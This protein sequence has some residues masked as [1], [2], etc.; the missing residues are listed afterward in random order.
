MHGP[1]LVHSL[2]REHPAHWPLLHDLPKGQSPQ[3]SVPPQPSGAV[4][5]VRPRAAQVVG[6]QGATQPPFWQTCPLPQQVVPQQIRSVP[7]VAPATAGAC[8]QA[9][10]TQSSTVHGFW[11]S[12]S[13][14]L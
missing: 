1:P 9:L 12:Q 6:V 7:H 10:P 4:P 5:H 3:S 8:W 11:S 2:S 14:F 13:L